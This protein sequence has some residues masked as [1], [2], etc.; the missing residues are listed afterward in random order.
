M[1]K[2]S[3]RF[4]NRH[5]NANGK[6]AQKTTKKWSNWKWIG[7]LKI[8]RKKKWKQ[9]KQ[10][11]FLN[12][13]ESQLFS[14]HSKND[15]LFAATRTDNVQQHCYHLRNTLDMTN[16]GMHKWWKNERNETKRKHRI[17]FRT[18]RFAIFLFL[19]WKEHNTRNKSF[20]KKLSKF[21]E[22]KQEF[23]SWNYV[24]YQMRRKITN[25]FTFVYYMIFV[26]LH[27]ILPLLFFVGGTI[28]PSFG[29]LIQTEFFFV[30]EKCLTKQM[31]FYRFDLSSDYNFV[32]WKKT[33][34]WNSSLIKINFPDVRCIFHAF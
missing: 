27:L 16:T 34:K 8:W 33:S 6:S 20:T 17:Q 3:R 18:F 30:I 11:H 19:G 13:N 22:W 2:Y 4:T 24:V 29:G 31:C 7:W 14:L 1:Y 25:R 32:M 15:G 23:M 5:P 28:F 10:R 12:W 9:K 21:D 26:Y